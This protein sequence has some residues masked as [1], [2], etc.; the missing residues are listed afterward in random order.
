[1][2]VGERQA[3]QTKE[4]KNGMSECSCVR[5][6]SK[7]MRFLALGSGRTEEEGG[8]GGEEAVMGDEGPQ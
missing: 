2:L 8:G 4:K 3:R 7:G 1:M 6:W 5:A